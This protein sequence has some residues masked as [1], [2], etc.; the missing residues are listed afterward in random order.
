MIRVFL[1]DDHELSR[2]GNRHI[3]EG[4]GDIEIVGEGASGEDALDTLPE[5]RPDI[6][7]CDLFLPGMSGVEVVHHVLWRLPA[8][9]VIVLSAQCEGPLPRRL[10]DAG[11]HGYLAKGCRPS[12]LQHAVRSVHA[13]ERYLCSATARHLALNSLADGPASPFDR[14]SQRELQVMVML[15]RGVDSHDIARRLFVSPKTI[16]SH[17]S[18]ALLKLGVSDMAQA[19]RM[20]LREGVV[21]P[22]G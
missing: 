2:F 12:E 8:T 20:A 14:L 1:L 4:G 18:N 15:L 5:V 6:L 17:K 13:G 3:L 11:I 16:S 9:R 7:L 19:M 21:D 22:R 10:L